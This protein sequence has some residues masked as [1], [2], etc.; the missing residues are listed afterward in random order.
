MP[1]PSSSQSR[2]RIA[3]RRA[4]LLVLLATGLLHT[5]DDA[6]TAQAARS[7]VPAQ[8]RAVHQLAHLSANV[9]AFCATLVETA[10]ATAGSADPSMLQVLDDAARARWLAAIRDA[11]QPD[12]ARERHLRAFAVG[13]E[14]DAARAVTDWYTSDTGRR[15]LALETSASE[16]D[17]ET[18]VSPF[19]DR[20]MKEP[21]DVERV[22]LF[23]RIE[24]ALQTTEDAAQLQAAIAEILTWSAQPLLPEAARTPP[25]EIDRELAALRLHFGQQ[26]RRQQSVIFMYV[27]RDASD[28]ELAAFADFAESPGARWLNASHRMAM[29]QL[30]AELRE[31]I[32]AEL[33]GV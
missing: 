31:E 18:E 32:V 7:P 24:A 5:I 12:A 30:V 26:L 27:Y 29:L 8:V 13:Y 6:S 3:W 9:E 33:G 16:T 21:V 23:E 22:K 28:A 15:L 20:L 17:W 1:N 2:S 11:C 25:A 14:A 19:I 10:E 4:A